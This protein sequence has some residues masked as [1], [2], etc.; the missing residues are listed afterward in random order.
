MIKEDTT[1]G[2]AHFH[3]SLA[4]FFGFIAGSM[5]GLKPEQL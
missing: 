4:R 2:S 1:M 5:K 3:G